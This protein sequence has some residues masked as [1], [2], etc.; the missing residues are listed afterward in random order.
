[1][2]ALYSLAKGLLLGLPTPHAQLDEVS[3]L[4]GRVVEMDPEHLAA[5][6]HLAAVGYELGRYPTAVAGLRAAHRILP[7]V[8]RIKQL[9]AGVLLQTGQWGMH[10]HLL[11]QSLATRRGVAY[12]AMSRELAERQAWWRGWDLKAIGAPPRGRG[13][14]NDARSYLEAYGHTNRMKL[15]HDADQ[16]EHLIHRGSLPAEGFQEAV[17]GMRAVSRDLVHRKMVE[18]SKDVPLPQGMRQRDAVY[19]LTAADRSAMRHIYNRV[20]FLPPT[21]TTL[22]E[23]AMAPRAAA[24]R[25]ALEDAYLDGKPLSHAFLDG[26]LTQRALQRLQEWCM[27]GTIWYE[28]KRDQ[29]YL[30]SYLDDGFS[31][32]LLYQIAD[33]LREAPSLYSSGPRNPQ[34]PILHWRPF[35]GYFAITR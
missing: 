17:R 1:M 16:I 11:R 33:E 22:P 5:Q 6:L 14:Q 31:T 20:V 15:E 23:P 21:D 24:D 25:R 26:F 9:L 12:P 2:S 7:E 13:H 29:G 4:L 34:C 27:S 18:R 28:I 30:G 32:P 3:T 8:D 10:Q 35:P 19:A